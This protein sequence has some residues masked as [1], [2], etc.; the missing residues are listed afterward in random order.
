MTS[1]QLRHIVCHDC[2]TILDCDW[3]G[4]SIDEDDEC[5]KATDENT[6]HFPKEVDCD[7][8]QQVIKNK[9]Q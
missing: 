2:L 6:Y 9:Q 7:C 1:H 4:I 3:L 8:E 5:P